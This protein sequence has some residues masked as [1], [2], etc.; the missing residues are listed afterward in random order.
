M[1]TIRT[2][3]MR[4]PL[5]QSLLQLGFGVIGKYHSF[6]DE[7]FGLHCSTQVGP[8]AR[9]GFR[10][11]NQQMGDRLRELGLLEGRP[12]AVRFGHVFAI[13]TVLRRVP[14][15]GTTAPL[16]SNLGD[17]WA[18]A[19][20]RFWRPYRPRE[21]YLLSTVEEV[22]PFAWVGKMSCCPVP[23]AAFGIEETQ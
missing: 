19:W 1:S 18:G 11:N 2:V 14:F 7:R 17:P 21:L 3:S 13:G 22:K 15:D 16:K 9:C 10:E 12:T 23:A 4:L 6:A 20:L 5:A 8:P